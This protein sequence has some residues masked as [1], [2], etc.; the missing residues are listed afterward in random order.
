VPDP[1]R[2]ALFLSLN[3]NKRSVTLDLDTATGQ[4]LFRALAERAAIVV[5]S[6][7]PGHLAE[8]GL[9]Y[10]ALSGA[11]EAL[12]MTSISPFGQDGPYRDYRA[13][14]MTLFALGGLMSLA[15][16]LSR[17][18]LKFGGTPALHTTGV[19]AFTATMLAHHLAE[20]AG[21]GQHVD[22]SALEGLAGSHFQDMMDYE[23]AGLVKR[24]TE[25]RLPI[26]A[27]DGFV[28]FTVQAHQYRDFQRLILG[29]VPEDADD[30]LVNRDRQ[31]LEGEMDT[32]I[33]EWT[34]PKTKY[35]AYTLAQQAH[36][37]TAFIADM[38]DLLESPQYAARGFWVEVDH[39]DAGTL[40]YPGFPAQLRGVEWEHRPPPRLG[41]HTDE[42][43]DAMAGLSPA[44][45]AEVRAAGVI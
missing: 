32:Q 34:V 39:Q 26:P 3:R 14:E 25:L 12:V 31:R 40:R 5:E 2:G 22:V 30:D 29:A 8:R 13:T 1:D 9:G 41:E 36:V 24:R 35:E 15:G 27:Q 10:E 33:L 17:E 6:W 18:P 28:S 21:L 23:Y 19:Y 43:L 38:D 7:P 45:I 16:D 37:P 44:E 42:V 20:E 11:H 4:E